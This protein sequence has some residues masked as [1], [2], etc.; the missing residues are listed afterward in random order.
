VPLTPSTLLELVILRRRAA[1]VA[2]AVALTPPARGQGNTQ[3]P[4]E[5]NAFLQ[6]LPELMRPWKGDWE[7]M[8]KRGVLRALVVYS[9]TFYFVDRGMQRGATYE[10]LKAFETEINKKL[11]TKALKFNVVFI[12]VS[13]DEL[14]PGLLEGRGDLAAASLTITPEREAQVDFSAPLYSGV[15][16]I[17]VTGPAGPRI[18]RLDDLSGK[19]I[20]VRKSSSYWEHLQGLNQRFVQEGK[21]PVKLVPASEELEDEDLLE[22]ANAGLLPVVVVDR[23]KARFWQ[24]LFKKITFDP[25]VAIATGGEIGWMMRKGSPQLKA[26]VNDFVKTHKQGTEFGNLLIQRYERNS[27]YVMEATSS[28]ELRKYQQTVDFFRKYAAKYDVDH[29]LMMAQGYQESRLDQQA[30]SA[31]GAVGIMQVMPATGEQMGVGDI[32]DV[33]PNI[34]AGVKYLRYLEDTYFADA[35]MEPV[36]KALFAFAS[37]NAGPGR[38]QE[39]RREAQRRGLNPNLW[40]RN[41]EYVVAEKIGQETVTY[42]ANIF[43]YYVAYQLVADEERER[44]AARK[45][46]ELKP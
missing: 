6:S 40:F 18:A 9:K 28:A 44:E 2:L 25:E 16:E 17:V 19:V 11:G 7:E 13:R 31:V 14:I 22:M 33:E 35:P 3:A 5:E 1:L 21:V 46:M 15:S 43:K 42:V 41:V 34:H 39:L 23:F 29:L 32:H 27:Q 37:Y 12:P 8:K 30:K 4:G 26:L 38:I 20:H 36:V 24:Q 10:A 45:Q